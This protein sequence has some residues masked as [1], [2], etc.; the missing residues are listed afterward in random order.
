MLNSGVALPGLVLNASD[1]PAH[2]AIKLVVYSRLL[3]GVCD[4]K[5]VF[6]ALSHFI[7]RGKKLEIWTDAGILC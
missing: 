5:V 1:K 7:K 3:A 6:W 4:G 2:C